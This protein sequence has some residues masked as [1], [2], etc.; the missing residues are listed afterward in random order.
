MPRIGSNA[1]VNNTL[2]KVI[3]SN[4]IEIGI[5]YLYNREQ[6]PSVNR[7]IAISIDNNDLPINKIKIKMNE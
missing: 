5:T 6:L 3:N 1:A 2:V 7:K 4:P